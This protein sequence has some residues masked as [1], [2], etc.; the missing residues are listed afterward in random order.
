MAVWTW[1]ISRGPLAYN[2]NPR[3]MLSYV[4][5][6]WQ[7]RR[8]F[9]KDQNRPPR[10]HSKDIYLSIAAQLLNFQGQSCLLLPTEPW[11]PENQVQPSQTQWRGAWEGAS[12]LQREQRLV[13][14]GIEWSSKSFNLMLSFVGVEQM[15]FWTP[16]DNFLVS[17]GQRT[18]ITGLVS[19]EQI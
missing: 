17:C 14:I 11:I 18:K 2:S 3:G 10:G 13:S 1:K 4:T 9:S 12:I 15:T 7:S 6:I 5:N 8:H 16:L 19:L